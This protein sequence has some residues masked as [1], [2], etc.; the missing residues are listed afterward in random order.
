MNDSK[1]HA[2][3]LSRRIKGRLCHVNLIPVNP[4]KET[5]LIAPDQNHEKLFYTTLKELGIAVT[6]R[7]ELGRDISASCGQLRNEVIS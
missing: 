4:V 7:R 3:E 6:V 2:I 5:G 1:E